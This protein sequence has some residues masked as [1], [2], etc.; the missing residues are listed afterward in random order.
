MVWGTNT[1]LDTLATID[2][3][4]ILD[5]GED[6]FFADFQ[7]ALNAHNAVYEDMI[8][9]FVEFTTDRVARYGVESR[10]T[11]V[12][13]DEFTRADAQK[14]APGGVD[15][16][17]PLR[18]YQATMQWTRLYFETA[19]PAD[20]AAQG[21]AAQRA[22]I[23]NGRATLQRAFFTPT[24]NLTYVDRRVDGVTVPLRALLNADGAAI[25]ADDFGNTFD[26]ATHTHY[27]GTAALTAANIESLLSTVIEHGV[28]GPLYLYINRAQEAAVIGFTGNFTAYSDPLTRP[29]GGSTADEAAGGTAMPFDIYNRAIG[30]WNGA[31]EVW[32][33]SWVPASY[34][35]AVDTDPSR[36]VLRYRTR[37][38]S[39]GRG[40]L[41]LVASDERYPLRAQTMER[42]FGVSV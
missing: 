11:M 17:W 1:I 38:G 31:V 22:D 37:P 42:E 20:I 16:G 6:R 40:Q 41:R 34:I 3:Q 19:T 33:K 26:G 39:A 2:S 30:V 25:P 21:V 5:Y 7:R 36:R 9:P 8:R 32:V 14:A 15:I 4:S 27:L 23:A 35:L 28:G 24:N 18:A 12:E 10:I 13:A 29:G